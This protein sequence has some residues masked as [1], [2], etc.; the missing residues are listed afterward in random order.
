MS[1]EKPCYDASSSDVK[2]DINL[3]ASELEKLSLKKSSS[4]SE[5]CGCK[6]EKSAKEKRK[7]LTAY[8]GIELENNLF[9]NLEVKEFLDK[10]P[11]LI[12][13]KKIHSTLLYVGKKE[14]N[15]D[16]EKFK[17]LEGT[18]CTITISGYGHSEKAMALKVDSIKYKT[19]DDKVEDIP[20]FAEQQHVTMALKDGTKA[21]DSV[22][23]LLGEGKIV[24]FKEPL[25]IDA[26]VKR[27][28]F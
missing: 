25:V 2:S 13:N 16:E 5:G 22:K 27:Y 23:T 19:S 10:H 17:G 28:L 26:K 1:Q 14:G 3:L 9:D 21:V 20:S 12:K 4:G 24:I 15:K 6:K 7:D 11:E 8:W 18:S